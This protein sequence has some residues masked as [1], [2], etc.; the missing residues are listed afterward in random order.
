[1][2]IKSKKE[3]IIKFIEKA[4]SSVIDKLEQFI[5]LTEDTVSSSAI[6]NKVKQDIM[7][8]PM[9]IEDYN[10]DI[11]IAINEIEKGHTIAHDEVLKRIKK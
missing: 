3:K 8:G 6:Y 7:G 10:R 1:M 4:D 9:S 2:D 11:E 5:A